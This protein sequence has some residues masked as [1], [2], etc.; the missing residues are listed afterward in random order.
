MANFSTPLKRPT[1]SPVEHYCHSLDSAAF[2]SFGNRVNSGTKTL[3]SG[4]L[5]TG[6]YALVGR[7]LQR[8]GSANPTRSSELDTPLSG[9]SLTRIS[10]PR[11]CDARATRHRCSITPFQTFRNR[12][13]R[14]NRTSHNQ[15]NLML[16]KRRGVRM[17]TLLLKLTWLNRD[18]NTA[19]QPKGDRNH[20]AFEPSHAIANQVTKINLSHRTFPSKKV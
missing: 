1:V 5:V 9:S 3:F 11:R 4:A 14:R 15:L 13:L 10:R 19:V 7:L 8:Y 17:L 20:H 18:P 6:A 2:P 12:K 16:I